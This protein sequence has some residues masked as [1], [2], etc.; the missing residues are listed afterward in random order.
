ML[1]VCVET[2]ILM[3]PG[4]TNC[5]VLAGDIDDSCVV[6][7]PPASGYDG[8]DCCECT[9]VSTEEFTCGDEDNGG[10][11]C[12]DPSAPCVD[13]DDDNAIDDDGGIFDDDVMFDDDMS[14]SFEFS[15]GLPDSFSYSACLDAFI[16]DGECDM[17]NNTEECGESEHSSANRQS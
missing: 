7:H 9:C 2:Q 5:L 17:D 12:I 1:G 6:L 13:D 14:A 10:F 3:V 15:F 4:S 8:G 16:G 11:A